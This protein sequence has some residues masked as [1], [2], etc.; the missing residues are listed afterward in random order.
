MNRGVTNRRDGK[1][2]VETGGNS[3]VFAKTN[4]RCET[5]AICN[6]H[7]LGKNSHIKSASLRPQSVV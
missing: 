5:A 7:D 6:P 4:H 1:V 2:A 3:K